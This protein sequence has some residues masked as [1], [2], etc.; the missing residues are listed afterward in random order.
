MSSVKFSLPGAD[1]ITLSGQT[2][3][4]LVRTG[5]GDAALLYLYILKTQGESTPEETMAAL[6]KG[7]GWINSAMAVLSRI[8]LIEI[9]NSDALEPP[10]A[11]DEAGL[12]GLDDESRQLS[13][14]EMMRELE[15]GSDFSIVAHETQC[16]FGRPLSPDE[17]LRLFGIFDNLNMPPE[18]ILHLITYCID[19]S[20]RSGGG[21]SS[22]LMRYIEKAAYTWVREGIMSLER[23]E[24][25]IKNLEAKRSVHG[26]I[27]AAMQIRDREFS[28]TERRYVD[29]WIAMGFGA[30]AIGIAYDRTIVKT[31]Q[32]AWNYMDTIVKSW[33][34][35]SLHTA[36]EIREKDSRAR[37]RQSKKAAP[38][39]ET[40]GVL[41]QDEIQRMQ[42]LLEKTKKDV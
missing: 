35:R 4:K 31:G 14:D 12:D 11:L 19:E 36:N 10:S 5:D 30:D 9:D 20:K 18:V 8:K 32:L 3:D 27:K 33:H 16:S 2:V 6:G 38:A 37:T 13:T 40:F 41:D 34:K 23:A 15:A 1:T 21:R 39:P 29:G 25:Y 22:S 24:E 7:L 26:E 42:R 28:E 17:L